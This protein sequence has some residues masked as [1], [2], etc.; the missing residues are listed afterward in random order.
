MH[1]FVTGGTGFIGSHFIKM[2]LEHGHTV[3]A[4]RRDGSQPAIHLENEPLWIQGDLETRIPRHTLQTCDTFVH[5]AAYGVAAHAME[6][7]EECFRW[8]V[9]AS[10]N[11]W[12]QAINAGIKHF[13]IVG[14]CSEY[15]ISGIESEYVT[16]ESVLKPAGAY[17]ASKAAAT[18]AAFALGIAK[19]LTMSIM[20]PFH[21]YG[22]GEAPTRFWQ[23]LRQA[24]LDGKDFPMTRGEQ[25]RDFIPVEELVAQ[26]MQEVETP[27]ASPGLPII[28]NMGTGRAQTLREFAEYWWK[29]WHATGKLLFG[30]VPYRENEVMRYV[31]KV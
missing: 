21:T 31:P 7:W 27:Q 19:K 6:N 10:L 2:A 16:V 5:I 17:H 8:N 24:A 18:Q 13:V 25:I 30:A 26:L 12:L 23:M 4:L 3:S 11:L 1:L 28:K 9:T 22:P 15:G 20:R 29:H 14:T